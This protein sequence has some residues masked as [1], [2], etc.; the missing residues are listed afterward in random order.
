M[1]KTL[2][3]LLTDLSKAFDCLQHDLLIA[4]L[5]AYGCS[6]NSLKLLLSYLTGRKHTTKI[7]QS[8]STWT[9]I[10][11]RVPQGS[12]LGPLL[13]N[14]YINDLF[15]FTE[16]FDVANYADDCTAYENK[17]TINEVITSLER[18]SICLLEWYRSNYLKP[19][20]DKHHLLLNE[21]GENWV[22]KIASDTIK[23]KR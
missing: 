14:I 6:T 11:F 15:M 10:I 23:N 19:N 22:L 13:F 20:L 7:N 3:L 12:I 17:F 21:V 16:E 4:K 8:Y 18:D 9:D 2:G 1:A 5:Y